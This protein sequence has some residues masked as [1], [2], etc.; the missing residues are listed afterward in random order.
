M[1]SS[2]LILSLFLIQGS[3]AYAQFDNCTGTCWMDGCCKPQRPSRPTKPPECLA[4]SE[5]T[6]MEVC[7]LISAKEAYALEAAGLGDKI[8]HHNDK[9]KALHCR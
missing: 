6:K 8:F 7:A 5:S 9:K 1:K 3:M 4:S 2:Y